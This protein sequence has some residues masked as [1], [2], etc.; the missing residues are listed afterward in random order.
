MIDAGRKVLSVSG[1][2]KLDFWARTV[3]GFLGGLLSIDSFPA[4]LTFFL[5]ALSPDLDQLGNLVG[6]LGQCVVLGV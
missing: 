6:D 2:G 1:R 4:M 3:P 5:A